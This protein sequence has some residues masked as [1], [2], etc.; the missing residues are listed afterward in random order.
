MGS[1][2]TMRWSSEVRGNV[3]PL[4][5]S[6]R[7]GRTRCGAEECLPGVD[8]SAY[9]HQCPG[10]AARA[11]GLSGH[12]PLMSP[13]TRAVRRSE[14]ACR[15]RPPGSKVQAQPAS[16]DSMGLDQESAI[17]PRDSRSGRNGRSRGTGALQ[18]GRASCWCRDHPATR[19]QRL[20]Q[21]SPRP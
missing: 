2:V 4:G 3:T 18:A 19:C 21:H 12:K 11:Q 16:R 15:V 5:T 6:P 9:Q 20:Q 13:P 1:N 8:P 7:Y 10:G 14:V 17:N